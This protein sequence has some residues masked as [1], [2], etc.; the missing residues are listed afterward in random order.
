M[1]RF[2]SRHVPVA[3]AVIA[4]GA[5]L[6]AC[7]GGS[8]HLA[9]APPIPTMGQ[10]SRTLAVDVRPDHRVGLGAVLTTK[11]G[12]QIFG[13]ALGQNDDSGILST[14]SHIE[15]FDQQTGIITGSFPKVIPPGTTYGLDGVFAGNTALVTRYVVPKGSIYAIRHYDVITP[16]T[17]GK[18]TGDWTPPVRDIDVQQAG[19]DPKS[20][21]SVLFAIELKNQDIPDLYASDIK[22][23]TFGKVIHLN[24]NTF[25]LGDQPQ[26]ASFII[27]GK[28]VL[29]TSPDGGRVGG[30][31][32]INALVDLKTGATTEFTGDNGGPFGAGYVNGMAL[33]PNTGIEVTTTELNAQVE[34]YDVRKKT[35]PE[36]VQ[37]PC[38]GNT[39]QGNS[40]AG[41]AVDPVHKLFLVADPAYACD[42][43]QDGA[44]VVY[45][46]S[47][48]VVE[49]IHPFKF[50]IA[51]PAP[52]I[53][54]SK[55]IGWAFGPQ[56]NQLQ[57]F[58]Y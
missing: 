24:P 18:F 16:F 32:P 50:A 29:V 3:L 11:D 22:A 45:D 19:Q 35:S 7:G 2:G 58:F 10:S 49:T 28:A 9:A 15:T 46:E 54:P 20:T 36:A 27:D 52:A 1:Q 53:D 39:D 47:G 42:N 21:T 25:L 4:A 6:A 37:L 14:A 57:E 51:E 34:F 31:A 38:T 40:G 33:D 23:N 44:L 30:E 12:G 41:I 13:F 5:A 26:L 55:R 43:S 8:T 48:K 56:F 17:A